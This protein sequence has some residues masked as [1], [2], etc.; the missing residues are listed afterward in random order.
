MDNTF[1]GDGISN[2][3]FLA[4]FGDAALQPDGKIVVVGQTELSFAGQNYGYL[5]ARFNSDGS[6]D[7]TFGSNGQVR[8]DRTINDP[9]RDGLSSVAVQTDGKILAAGQRAGE[10]GEILRLDSNGAID[11]TFGNAG[12]AAF[13]TL[14]FNRIES[15]VLTAGGKILAF[16]STASNNSA[17][18]FRLNPNGGADFSFGQ[19][20][21]VQTNQQLFRLKLQPDEKILAAGNDIRRLLPD[22]SPD[23]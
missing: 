2:V 3:G 7:Q 12:Y 23:L 8:I 9:R 14:N 19:N 15:L 21:F 13:E 16:G 20:G 11:A 5:I 17:T 1:S 22:G 10:F 18:I 4:S 6:L